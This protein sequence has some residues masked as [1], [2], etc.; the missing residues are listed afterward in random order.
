M[1]ARLPL[2][3]LCL[4]AAPAALFAQAKPAPQVQP[5]AAPSP[6]PPP[7]TP[8]LESYTYDPGGRRDPFT[9]L[10]GAGSGPRVPLMRGEGKAGLAVAELSVRGVMQNRGGFI[11]M[12]QGP[13]GKTFLIRSG[14]KLADGTVR[15]VNAEGIVVV[16]DVND[17]LS[18][19]KQREV[20]KKLRSL[21]AKQ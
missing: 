21:E 8:Q 4:I 20:S 13:D 6:P 14:D 10:L 15:A 2:L 16:Q 9:N 18:L 1:R 7:P 12:V 11:A 5:A 3:V 19:V 17:P